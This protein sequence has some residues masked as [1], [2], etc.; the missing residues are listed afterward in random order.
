[1][2]L[3][4]AA[5]VRN[6]ADV[7]E[8]FVRHNLGVLDGLAIVDHGSLDATPDIL[9]SLIAEGLPVFLGHEDAPA[10]DAQ[11][12][13]NQLVRHVFA[14][15]DADWVFPLDADEF[16]K[17]P[18]RGVLEEA[19]AALAGLSH[20]AMEWHTYVP[21]FDAGADMLALLRSARRLRDDGHGLRKVAV[22]R[23]FAARAE[24]FMTK[25]QH[26]VETRTAGGKEPHP[27][28]LPPDTAVL[29]HVPVR[30]A[31]QF[32]AKIAVNRLASL[33]VPER[34]QNE[35]IHLREAYEYIAS[36][37]PLTPGQLKAFAVN[38][39]VPMARWLPADAHV[40][41]DD[42]FLA[43]FALEYTREANLDPLAL[44]LRVAERM[45]GPSRSPQR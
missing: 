44:V 2:R 27:A 8:A 22:S 16:L 23:A 34:E 45:I 35:S 11:V 32:T 4:G 29:A 40:L 37:R 3:I 26:R 25:G 39:S 18:E 36:G 38:Y 17:T 20:V 42:P 43:D 33:N 9:R 7:V 41:Q 12:M 6:E 31:R 1:V 10:W 24:L 13:R 14:T 15:S 30:S 19:L 28:V 5:Q 21:S